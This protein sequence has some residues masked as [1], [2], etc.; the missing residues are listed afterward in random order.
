ML[1]DNIEFAA[2]GKGKAGL[3]QK[4]FGFI[5]VSFMAMA[6]ARTVDLLCL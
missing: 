5:G 6:K 2:V 4:V 3:E 1:N